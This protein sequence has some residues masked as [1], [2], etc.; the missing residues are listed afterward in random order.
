MS[1]LIDE[2]VDVLHPRERMQR[3]AGAK[4]IVYDVQQNR[5]DGRYR[6]TLLVAK[7]AVAEVGDCW[8]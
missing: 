3:R 7:V 2:G 6:C 4:I 8:D 1:R 5:A